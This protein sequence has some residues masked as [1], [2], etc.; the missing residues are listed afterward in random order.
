MA[1][2]TLVAAAGL[3]LAVSLLYLRVGQLVLRRARDEST[4]GLASF[5]L[6]WAGVGAYGL[7]DSLWTLAS[8]A[9]TPPLALGVT[10]LHVKLLGGAAGF[11]GLVNYLLLIYAG[12]RRLVPLVAALYVVVY[13]ALVYWYAWRDPVGQHL[14]RWGASLDYANDNPLAWRG[15]VLMLFVPPILATLAYAL[16]LRVATDPLQRLR[17][18]LVSMSLLVFFAGLTMGWLSGRWPWWGLAEKVLALALAGGVL[19]SMRPAPRLA[20][21]SRA[22]PE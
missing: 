15:V 8:V 19:M 11:F 17:V 18:A 12:K 21:A 6:F 20:R 3:A 9:T 10:V 5:A 4:P 1:L 13:A 16:L 7:A 2:S 14:G 22:A